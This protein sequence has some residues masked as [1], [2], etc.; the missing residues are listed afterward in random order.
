MTK[1]LIRLACARKTAKNWGG[2]LKDLLVATFNQVKSRRRDSWVGVGCV[3]ETEAN[4]LTGAK[5]SLRLDR[6]IR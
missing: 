1:E 3:L 6:E 5:D 4:I 2:R